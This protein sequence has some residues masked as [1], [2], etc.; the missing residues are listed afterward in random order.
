MLCPPRENITLNKPIKQTESFCDFI[1]SIFVRDIYY[2]VDS[3]LQSRLRV[4][5]KKP[6][7]TFISQQPK[8][9]ERITG[10]VEASSGVVS[11]ISRVGIHIIY[12]LKIE[13]GGECNSKW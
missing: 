8:I 4:E 11:D 6:D 2:M 3:L 10:S 12:D 9:E 5:V 1:T 7:N 13:N